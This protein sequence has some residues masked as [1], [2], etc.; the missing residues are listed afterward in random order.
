[1]HTCHRSVPR[2]PIE[3]PYCAKC[4]TRMFLA[5]IQPTASNYD[6]RTFECPTCEHTEALTVLYVP[7]H[8]VRVQ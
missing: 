3:R 8:T 1:M 2:P 7:T 4:G 6:L 5:R